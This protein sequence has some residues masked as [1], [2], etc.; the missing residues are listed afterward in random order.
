MRMPPPGHRYVAATW[1]A[2]VAAL[3][4]VLLGSAA[5]LTVRDSLPDDIVVRWDDLRPGTTL[6]LSWA[7][8]AGAALTIVSCLTVL[9]A[10]V[11]VNRSSKHGYAGYAAG[12]SLAL[13]FGFY[14]MTAAQ[15]WPR[16]SDAQPLMIAGVVV[17][18]VA[19]WRL[20]KWVREP[21]RADSPVPPAVA[22]AD[23]PP[24]TRLMWSRSVPTPL[25]SRLAVVAVMAVP[26]VAFY[27]W[28]GLPWWLSV[29]A[30]GGAAL[31][32]GFFPRSPQL[33]IDYS[34]IGLRGKSSNQPSPIYLAD[35]H[36]AEVAIISPL[37]DFGG[38]GNVTAPDGR[39]GWVTRSGE[40][41]VVHRHAK[42]DFVVTVDGADEAAAVL[43]TLV[44]R[45]RAQTVVDLPPPYGDRMATPAD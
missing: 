31:G 38:W 2:V 21:A 11:A 19:G 40:A 20:T 8:V 36:S 3:A 15:A 26:L 12:L 18:S 24:T 42:P 16:F 1:I 6:S 5:L 39:Q 13:G 32:R 27:W 34:G 23:L 33:A 45:L 29:A 30:L 44:A 37:R 17:G 9:G 4:T 35:V 28:M 7:L 14:A 25:R 22:V 43:N 41:L 10:G